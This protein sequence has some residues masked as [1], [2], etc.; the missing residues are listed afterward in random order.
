MKVFKIVGSIF[1]PIGLIFL[2][3]GVM[4]YQGTQSFLSQSKSAEGEVIDLV[5]GTSNSS[6][7]RSS[8]PVVR[9]KSDD[10]QVVTFQ[11]SMGSSPPDF[12]VGERVTVRY[13]VENP[14][15]ARIESF[16]QL[17]LL[18]MVFGGLGLI[19]SSIGI[20]FWAVVLASSRKKKWLR[21][22]GQIVHA[23]INSVSLDTSLRVN[24]QHPYRIYAQRLDSMHNTV[25]VFKSDPIW[26]DP[27][28]HIHQKTVPVYIDP[29]NPKKYLMDVSFLPSSS[30]Q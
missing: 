19:F 27:E 18:P 9:F 11:G 14:H 28:S 6:G 12:H 13:H 2:V 26:Y 22:H 21:A 10:G 29:A 25:H 8:Y 17:W 5:M 30:S 1:A 24:G 20:S 23:K 4:I 15:D 3:V 16:V 7:S